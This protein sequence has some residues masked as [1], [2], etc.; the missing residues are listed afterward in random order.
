MSRD[1]KIGP[2]QPDDKTDT[3]PGSPR[4][5]IE[6]DPMNPEPAPPPDTE[7][8]D[9]ERPDLGWAEHED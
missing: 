3:P 2:N 4:D 5:P 7:S 8:E 9:A 6:P 1:G